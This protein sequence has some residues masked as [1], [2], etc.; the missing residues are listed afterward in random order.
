MRCSPLTDP[1]SSVSHA[2]WRLQIAD[3]TVAKRLCGCQLQQSQ[4]GGDL[5]R[6][7]SAGSQARRSLRELWR[8]R[9][10]VETPCAARP[11]ASAWSLT[12][13]RVTP[14]E[15]ELPRDLPM[16][17]TVDPRCVLPRVSPRSV[18]RNQRAMSTQSEIRRRSYAADQTTD[19]W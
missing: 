17:T 9:P 10:P 14:V 1:A 3:L 5:C 4:T 7:L 2:S 11:A 12:P 18:R 19:A 13:Q 8:E 6:P 16:V 15:I